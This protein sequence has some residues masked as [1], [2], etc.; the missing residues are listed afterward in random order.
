MKNSARCPRCGSPKV[1]HLDA[2]PDLRGDPDGLDPAPTCPQYAGVVVVR[3]FTPGLFGSAERLGL[4]GPLEAYVCTECGYYET[5]VK[6]PEQVPF[7]RMRGFTWLCDERETQP[8][9][10]PV[11]LPRP[12]AME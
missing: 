2:V 9:A 3:A 10:A 1:G 11:D 4:A 7:Q 5:Y 8:P 6:S 12:L